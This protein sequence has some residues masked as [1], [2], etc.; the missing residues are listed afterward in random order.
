MRLRY[1]AAT[2][3]AAALMLT[4]GLTGCSMFD[5]SGDGGSKSGGSKTGASTTGGSTAGG[6]T[7]GASTAGGAVSGGIGVEG[8][9]PSVDGTGAAV[10]KATFDSPIYPGAKVDI[11]VMG[12]KASGKLATLTVQFAPHIPAGG[13]DNPNP[14]NLNGGNSLGTALIDPVNLKRYVVV[15]DSDHKKLESDDIFTHIANNQ[16]ATLAYTYAAPPENVKAVD[17]QIGSWPTFRNIP[18]AR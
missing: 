4:G 3:T 5:D 18:V 12:L 2:L 7:A 15:A 8:G 14:Y 6:S 13:P 17:V 11:A 10:V 9:K 1:R 16:T